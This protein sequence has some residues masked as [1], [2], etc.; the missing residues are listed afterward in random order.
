MKALK[1]KTPCLFTQ[2]ELHEDVQNGIAITEFAGE[3]VKHTHA[4][5]IGESDAIRMRDWLIARYPVATPV[6]Q[7]AQPELVE[8]LR[9]IDHRNDNPARFDAEIDAIIRA[10]LVAQGGRDE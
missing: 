2:C 4:I 8:A 9:K 3:F 5:S 7:P 10:A 6:A 1:F